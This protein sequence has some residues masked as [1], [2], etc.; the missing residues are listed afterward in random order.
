MPYFRKLDPINHI[1]AVGKQGDG[2]DLLLVSFLYNEHKKGSKIY[3]NTWLDFPF[4]EVN[5]MN[6]IVENID[7]SDKNCLYLHDVD[8]IYSSR[9][10][11]VDKKKYKN[12]VEILS[13]I[14][15]NCRKLNTQLLIS[16]HRYKNIEVLIRV[17]LKYVVKCRMVRLEYTAP[18]N[19]YDYGIFY[20]VFDTDLN[21]V[22]Y[23]DLLRNLPFYA[24]KFNT[25]DMVKPLV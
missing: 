10:F 24:K 6:D 4:K 7:P 25:L 2:K 22:V 16:A 9:T 1:L 14:T 8:Q 3:S 21:K 11:M 18:K 15:N 20:R 17:L 13:H 23:K 5:S 12:S 19:F